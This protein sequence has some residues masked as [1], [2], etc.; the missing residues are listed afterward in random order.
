MRIIS[1]WYDID[2]AY[3]GKVTDEGFYGKISRYKNISQVLKMLE[4]TKT[5]HFKIEGR[6]VTLMQ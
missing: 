2:V 4:K 3:E 6:R 5:V 1:R